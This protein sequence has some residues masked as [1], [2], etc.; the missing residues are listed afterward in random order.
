MLNIE[1]G[2]FKDE[3]GRVVFLRGINFAAD[4]KHP[5][6]GVENYVNCPCTIEEADEHFARIKALG[7]NCVRFLYTWD[8]LQPTHPDEIN[9]AFIDHAIALV[10]KAIDEYGF[11]VFM[12]PH[13]DIWSRFCGGSG[14]PLWTL[15]AAGLDHRYFQETHAAMMWNPKQKHQIKMQWASNSHRLA[16]FTMFTLFFGGEEYAPRAVLNGVNVG[17]Y[18]RQK[19][20][21]AVGH[22]MKRF[23][24]ANLGPK[25]IG[26]ESLNEPGHG[27]IGYEHLDRFPKSV[28]HVKLGTSP[29]P[30][31][32]M[33][34]GQGIAQH[35]GTYKFTGFGL[36][37]IQDYFQIK[38]RRGT[39]LESAELSELDREYGW[40]RSWPGGCIWELHGI[41]DSVER[42]LLK[43]NYFK[44]SSANKVSHHLPKFNQEPDSEESA[45]LL[46]DQT[47]SEEVLP[48]SISSSHLFVEYF[49][50]RHWLEFAAL[51]KDTNP[52]WL[53]FMQAP[54]NTP[55]PNMVKHWSKETDFDRL[56]YTPHYYDGLTLMLKRWRWM[57]VDA[58]GVMRDLYSNPLPAL[59]FGDSQICRSFADQFEF[60]KKEGREHLGSRAPLLM[61]EIG[62]PYDMDKKEAFFSGYWDNQIR[63]MNANCLGLESAKLNYTLWC[64]TVTNSNALGDGFSGEDLSIFSR[65]NES[66]E[67]QG[68]P[69]NG[70]RAVQAVSRPSPIAVAGDL[71]ESHFDLRRAKYTLT[72]V[73]RSSVPTMVFVPKYHFPHLRP[74]FNANVT[75]GSLSVKDE[76]TLVWDHGGSTD[77]PQ[78]LVINGV[79]R[80]SDSPYS[81]VEGIHRI[82]QGLVKLILNCFNP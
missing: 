5:R 79:P 42:K 56:V 50:V 21:A 44:G 18:L 4:M 31:Q 34:L 49:F 12:D 8:A 9:E 19:Y 74:L 57:N 24:D 75:E 2:N 27:L 13:Q 33:L 71:I 72:V 58:I 28:V 48:S 55:P 7:F 23:N 54:V 82:F 81:Y 53:H 47:D 51:V 14:A 32:A 69:E 39:W 64:Y 1:D 15:H 37:K 45:S 6:D 76:T 70:V 43:P 60:L 10:R 67:L 59:R 11:Y 68:E 22:M 3:L 78:T 40:Q 61:S 35:V 80:F 65:D 29:T 30:F 17:T 46:S 38:P 16:C 25:L 62:I 77:I 66:V 36:K 20:F 52:N 73:P 63:A 41:Y 26:W